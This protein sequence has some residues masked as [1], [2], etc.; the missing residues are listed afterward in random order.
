[1]STEGGHA[2]HQGHGAEHDGHAK[3]HDRHVGHSPE[4]FRSRFWLSLLL[5]VPVVYWSEHI[6]ML[7][8]Y[9]ALPLPGAAWIPPVLGTVVFLYGG[10][11][12]LR[13]ALAELRARL[14]GMMTLISLAITVAFLFS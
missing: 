2:H 13:G 7:L 4:M 1:M 9:R 5:T 6:E 14:P 11:V 10:L 8:G 12:F 3:H